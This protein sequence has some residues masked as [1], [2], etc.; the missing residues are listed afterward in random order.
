MQQHYLTTID[1]E[2]AIQWSNWI[3]INENGVYYFR[4][5]IIETVYPQ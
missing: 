1:S 2:K 5:A 3:K 4:Y